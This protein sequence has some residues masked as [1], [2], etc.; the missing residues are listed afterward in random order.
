MIMV[1]TFDSPPCGLFF[2]ISAAHCHLFIH[3]KLLCDVT[4]LSVMTLCPMKND[5][6]TGEGGQR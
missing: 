4:E 5:I 2:L 6:F 3:V 1:L